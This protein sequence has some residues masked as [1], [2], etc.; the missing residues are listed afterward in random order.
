MAYDGDS[1]DL[2]TSDYLYPSYSGYQTV[3]GHTDSYGD[4]DQ[5]YFVP[6]SSGYYDITASSS[7]INAYLYDI[8]SSAYLYGASYQSNLY[9]NSS[10]SYYVR[11][12][13]YSTGESYNVTV[14]AS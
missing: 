10:H 12:F 13:G 8:T 6:S 7:N 11:V 2:T 4:M 3:Y 9:V 5:G 1:A 14:T